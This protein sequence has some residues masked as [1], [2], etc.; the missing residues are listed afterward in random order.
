MIMTELIINPGI[1]TRRVAEKWTL[2]LPESNKTFELDEN[3]YDLLTNYFGSSDGKSRSRFL[4]SYTE[5]SIESAKIEFIKRR[6]LVS[7]VDVNEVVEQWD[8]WTAG[9]WHLHLS[10]RDTKFATSNEEQ[11]KVA[12]RINAAE[13]PPRYKCS[14]SAET[15]VPLPEPDPLGECSA[16][17]AFMRRRTCR[18][19]DTDKEVSLKALASALYYSGG[20][21][22]ENETDHFGTVL[23]KCSPSPGARHSIEQYPVVFRCEGLKPG[24]YHY[25]VEHHRLNAIELGDQADFITTALQQQAYF[26]ACA[27]ACFMTSVTSRLRWKY[28]GPRIYK[29]IHLE[30]GHYCQNFLLAGTALGLGVF[31]T[32]AIKEPTVERKLRIDGV[33]EIVMYVAGLGHM[34]GNA[35]YFRPGKVNLIRNPEGVAPT[36]P[37]DDAA[38][39]A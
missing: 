9:A 38:G 6:I 23:K 20:V 12:A 22:F 36:L 5:D 34:R 15:S 19:F 10:A 24:I 13:A 14:C 7:T 28:K 3:S 31:S 32:G 29:L 16:G 33:D 26:T 8:G 17:A 39:L 37:R 4:N 35:P 27:V 11:N 1:L 25:C 18:L 30:A 21:V 2:H